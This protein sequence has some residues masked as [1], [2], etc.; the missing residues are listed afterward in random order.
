MCLPPNNLKPLRCYLDEGI[1]MLRV[2]ISIR[3]GIATPATRVR[4]AI[5]PKLF[6]IMATLSHLPA[7]SL[8][9]SYR[10]V[11]TGFARSR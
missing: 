9:D 4:Y 10:L 6:T 1:K 7:I 3:I 8:C 2:F 5:T 11:L